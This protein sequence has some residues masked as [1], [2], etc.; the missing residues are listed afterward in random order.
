MRRKKSGEEIAE[1]TLRN[2][3]ESKDKDLTPQDLIILE[4]FKEL[5]LNHNQH[6]EP[7]NQGEL[8]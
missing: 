2:S 6:Q 7:E 1:I 3:P 8:A 4:R 5:L